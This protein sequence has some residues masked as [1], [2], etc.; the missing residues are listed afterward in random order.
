MPDSGAVATVVIGVRRH[1][2]GFLHRNVAALFLDAVVVIDE[3]QLGLETLALCFRHLGEGGDDEQV[4]HG[5]A[6]R[7]RA[8]DR[9][10]AGAAFAADGVGDETLAIVDVPDVNLFVLHQ[11][12]GG[13]QVFVDGAGAFVMQLAVGDGGAVDLGF[14]QGAVHGVVPSG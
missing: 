14:E 12:G 10:D 1:V 5:G 6:A 4:A 9:D 2:G 3:N 13:Q 7:G 8:V 11:V